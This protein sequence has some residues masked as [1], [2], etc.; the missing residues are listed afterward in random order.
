MAKITYENKVALNVNPDIA[1]V[2]KCNATDLNEITLSDK[3]FIEQVKKEVFTSNIYV[4]TL[5]GEI[6]ELPLGA[7]AID[8]AY[9]IHTDYGN[10]LYKV[11][12]NGKE[13]K[14]THKLKDKDRIF[15]VK[16]DSVHPQESWLA[17][18]ITTN[19][20]RKIKESLRKDN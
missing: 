3:D 4:Y 15:V 14:I 6:V 7:T 11:Y 5:S 18:A 20:I 9:K 17:N 12:V 10:H 2:N 19:A 16:K 1:D 13:V 8:F